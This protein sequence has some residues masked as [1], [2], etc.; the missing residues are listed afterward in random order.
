MKNYRKTDSLARISQSDPIAFVLP[1]L[2]H[3]GAQ[4]VFLEVSTYLAGEGGL[5][6]LIVLD[7]EGELLNRLPSNLNVVF[8]DSGKAKNK[9]I[10]RLKQW[11]S[12]RVVIK[13]KGIHRVFSTITGMNVF[14]LSCFW[15]S[16]RVKVVIREATTLENR[17]SR[18]L[19]TLIKIF[20]P[21]ANKVIC[22]SQ[23]IRSQLLELTGLEHNRVVFLPNPVD[24]DQIRRNASA[25]GAEPKKVSCGFQVVAVGRLIRAKGFDVLI[26]ALSIA[27]KSVNI[28]LVIVGEGPERS[29]LEQMITQLG[30]SDSVI[31]AGYQSNPHPFVLASDL[32]VLSSR[33]EGYVN[34]VV[35]AMVLGVDI[36]ATDCN[37]GPGTMLHEELGYELGSVDSPEALASAIVERL[38]CPRD[39][40]CFA[41]L[42]KMHDMPY[43]F[44]QY[45]GEIIAS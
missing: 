37:S 39:T 1:S 13:Q 21:R 5:V 22:T 18:F 9:L 16:S 24:C 19:T 3:G 10:R 41:P 25:F 28:Q 12:L 7:K 6:F 43:A 32:Y 29:T 45:I 42:V 33:W 20:Y 38:S 15:F 23:Y 14:T 27:R 11:F 26:E 36:V 35:E 4:K 34:T 8:L 31:L 30:L 40:S 2:A 17:P 44:N